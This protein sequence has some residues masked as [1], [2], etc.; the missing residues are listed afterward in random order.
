[1]EGSGQPLETFGKGFKGKPGNLE[2]ARPDSTQLWWLQGDK[3]HRREKTSGIVPERGGMRP[4]PRVWGI[5]GTWSGAGGRGLTQ[6]PGGS[7][8]GGGSN[9]PGV[10]SRS[11]PGPCCCSDG[12]W[13][14]NVH[15]SFQ[16]H[17]TVSI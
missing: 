9:L 5:Q 16:F 10:T 12:F 6:I 1:M 17:I 14:F 3:Q 2:M 13:G 11:P 7:D 8:R 15:F 4:S